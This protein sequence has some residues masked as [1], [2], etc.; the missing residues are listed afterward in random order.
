[1]IVLRFLAFLS[2]AILILMAMYG[3]V[4]PFSPE[5]SAPSPVPAT[6][7]MSPGPLPT[8][9]TPSNN[10]LLEW[11][12]WQEVIKL[13]PEPVLE[14]L[15]DTWAYGKTHQ[16]AVVVLG[17]LMCCLAMLLA[18]RIRYGAVWKPSRVFGLIPKIRM[19]QF[20]DVMN[21]LHCSS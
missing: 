8:A 4:N 19:L 14:T 13:L 7:G 17:L 2:C 10:T 11:L 1:M 3:S 18:G 12:A 5:P 6:N 9:A 20:F 15:R 21:C 16:I